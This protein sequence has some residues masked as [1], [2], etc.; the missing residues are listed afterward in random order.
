LKNQLSTS[1]QRSIELKTMTESVSAVI[2]NKTQIKYA[3]NLPIGLSEVEQGTIHG[4]KFFTDCRVEQTE[5]HSPIT[6]SLCFSKVAVN[7]GNQIL[8]PS[9]FY[10]YD[11]FDYGV[12]GSDDIRTNEI[13]I[14]EIVTPCG[15]KCTSA[16]SP[17]RKFAFTPNTT[18]SCELD[19]DID[20]ISAPGFHFYPAHWMLRKNVGSEYT[21]TTIFG[22]E[23]I[24]Q[25]PLDLDSL[26]M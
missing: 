9:E 2:V 21:S 6:Y 7:P 17:F 1:N 18:Y 14:G 15:K 8:R 22:R 11:F 13:V 25:T 16:V 26:F 10:K 24:H 23:K 20:V 5:A 4:Y 12:R 19:K 3:F